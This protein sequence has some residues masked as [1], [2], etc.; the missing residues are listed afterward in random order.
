M[1]ALLVLFLL[2]GLDGAGKAMKRRRR[3]PVNKV[4]PIWL[5]QEIRKR[6]VRR[7]KRCRAEFST[8]GLDYDDDDDE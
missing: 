4:T 1:V 8:V 5:V 7:W 2:V 3:V 6:P